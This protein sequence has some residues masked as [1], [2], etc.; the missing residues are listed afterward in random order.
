[1]S[2]FVPVL[3][4]LPERLGFPA[5]F[6]REIPELP[7]GRYLHILV[8]RETRGYALFTTETGEEQTVET[9]PRSLRDPQPVDRLVV[10][11]RKTVAAERRR[12]RALLRGYGGFPIVIEG[13]RVLIGSEAEG[14]SAEPR[15]AG[16]RG[17]GQGNQPIRHDRCYHPENC[18]VCADCLLYG[19]AA[20][21]GAQRQGNQ[22]SRVLTDS[23]FSVT[24]YA[25]LSR[26]LTFNYIDER[27]QTSGTVTEYD[28]TRPGIVFPAVVSLAD[29]TPEEAAF[30]LGTLLRTSRYGKEQS[31][32]GWV[33]NHIVALAF[34]DTELFS[35][36]EWTLAYTQVFEEAG[37][38]L[39]QVHL[40]DF[41]KHAKASVDLL[42]P[43]LVGV[44]RWVWGQ[45]VQG[46]DGGDR[47]KDRGAAT[48]GAVDAAVA[49]PTEESGTGVEKRDQPTLEAVLDEIRALY[50]DPSR[51]TRFVQHLNRQAAAAAWQ[52]LAQQREEA[53]A[54]AAEEE[55]RDASG[56]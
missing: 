31:R 12:G 27:S 20:L 8:L 4:A 33:R 53:G 50:A 11:K 1:M 26:R 17:R 30:V 3:N 29:P 21:E 18:G 25:L 45:A 52:R 55:Q 43:Y 16:R 44:C 22:R 7:R 51:L 48:A 49:P 37:Q 39:A 47:Q 40:Q 42:T 34:A 14:I 36:L 24:P 13:G 38:D 28:Y 32:Q 6:A 46:P 35:S 56:L 19:F 15:R 10:F 23:L 9:V 41:Y 2:E 5:F 54:G